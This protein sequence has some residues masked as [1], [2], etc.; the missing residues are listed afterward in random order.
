MVSS[1]A[2]SQ[3]PERLAHR[4]RSLRKPLLSFA[5]GRDAELIVVALLLGL[6]LLLRFPYLMR[7]PHFTDE[8]NE[9]RWAMSI[10]VE[11]NRP[12]T[13]TSQ[14]GYSGPLHAYIVAAAFWL[15]GPRMALPR[16]VVLGFGVLAVGA[17][18]LLGRE[19][20]G[21]GAGALGAALLATNPQHIVVNSHIAW[22]N[23]TTPFYSALTCWALVRALRRTNWR[24][25]RWDAG[26]RWLAFAAF[27]FG[28][29]LQTHI[30][31]VVLVP[32]LIL[33]VAI[34]AAR[35]R[36]WRLLRS[37]WPLLAIL[38]ALGGFAP[39]LAYNVP[40]A[41]SGVTRA[42]TKR[43]YAYENNPSWATYR[44][45]LGNLLGELARD[46]SNPFRIPERA[47]HYLTSPYLVISA[48][49]LL[50]GLALLARRGQWL[51]F[52]AVVS[53]AAIV[54]YFN[55]AYGVEG[56]RYLVTGRYIGFLLPLATVAIAVAALALTREVVW[57]L[58]PRFKWPS[59]ALGAAAIVTLTF[60][61]LLPLERY[62]THES[63]LDPDNATFLETVRLLRAMSAPGTPI[64]LDHYLSRIDLKDGAEA[65]DILDY[66]LTLDRVPHR[67]VEDPAAE[68]R[69]LGFASSTADPRAAPL[70]VM[71][72]DRCFRIREESPLQQ[73]SPPLRLRELY[74]TLP[75]YY[76][77]YR[78][79]PDPQPG[80][81]LPPP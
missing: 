37:P 9:V 71:M 48:L 74:W 70:I 50:A 56:D 46:A 16:A 30:G 57:R 2:V 67:I 51:P 55:H 10:L 72:R 34:P 18:Y 19:L 60:Y 64:L 25:Q 61:P 69:R 23:S 12:L 31:A 8:T 21:K 28:L 58:P 54:P 24:N 5:R 1:T 59:R 15:F 27:L 49:L 33:S 77:I 7:L 36:A 66:L 80:S 63:R 43:Q 35:A 38:A 42:A 53:T 40:R 14:S 47:L 81:C 41:F 11:G 3:T 76:A 73:V 68:L 22:Q 45:N 52:L 17:T 26:G 75:S 79:Q 6:A 65:L 32:A 29:T 78:Y 4:R 39:V 13:V 44:H 20:A 62:Y